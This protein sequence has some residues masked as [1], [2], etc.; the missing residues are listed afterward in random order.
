MAIKI[1]CNYC[2]KFVKNATPKEIKDLTGTEICSDCS[3][4]V[5]GLFD[6]VDTVAKRGIVRIERARDDVKA[7]LEESLRHVIKGG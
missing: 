4:H 6:E 5:R 2:Q 3:A 1:F 7:K